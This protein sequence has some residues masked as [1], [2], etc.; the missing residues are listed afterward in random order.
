MIIDFKSKKAPSEPN[1]LDEID[2]AFKHAPD[3]LWSC[4]CGSHLFYVSTDSF[5][6]SECGVEQIF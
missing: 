1:Q 5:V 6:C 3:V 2:E 4:H